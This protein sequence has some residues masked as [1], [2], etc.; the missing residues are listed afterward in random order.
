MN[1]YKQ[2]NTLAIIAI[3]LGGLGFV[4]SLLSCV[5]FLSVP[6]GVLGLILGA[7]AYFKARDNG[8]KKTLSIVALVLSFLPLLISALW[9]FTFK[10]SLSDIDAADY[11]SIQSCDTLQMEINKL[12]DEIKVLES[13]LEGADEGAKVFGSIT[14]LTRI[15]INITKMREQAD[16]LGCDLSDNGGESIIKIDSL[17]EEGVIEEIDTEDQ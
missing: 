15:T 12:D 17:Y 5:G 4:L 14:K 11:S 8:D 1:D 2:D 3:V 13:E 10:S 7:I 6:L 16:I 9:F